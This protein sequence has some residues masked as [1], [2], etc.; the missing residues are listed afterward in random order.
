M[1]VVAVAVAVAA[2]EAAWWQRRWCGDMDGH[3]TCVMKSPS[4]AMVGFR[5]L[6]SN[7]VRQRDLPVR[8]FLLAS[9][10]H[11]GGNFRLPN[12]RPAGGCCGRAER[13]TLVCLLLAGLTFDVN[14]VGFAEPRTQVAVVGVRGGEPQRERSSKDD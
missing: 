4:S 3:P 2:V 10:D 8:R 5:W 1:A 14:W 6:P 12:S 11:D 9:G 7:A 13:S